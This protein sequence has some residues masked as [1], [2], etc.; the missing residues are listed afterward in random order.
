MK[1]TESYYLRVLKERQKNSKRLKP[2]DESGFKDIEQVETAF[3][4]KSNKTN[5]NL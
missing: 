4:S 1:D 3:K 5:Y 2:L